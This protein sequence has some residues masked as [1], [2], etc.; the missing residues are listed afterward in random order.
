LY[1]C[2]KLVITNLCSEVRRNFVITNLR[3]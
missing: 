1:V 3:S 2:H